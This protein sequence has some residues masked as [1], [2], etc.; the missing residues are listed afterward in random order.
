MRYEKLEHLMDLALDMQLNRRGVSIKDIENKFSVSRRTA[1]RMKDLVLNVFLDIEEITD[2]TRIKR[3]KIHET[4]FSKLLPYNND[5]IADLTLAA[6]TLK[7][8][9]LGKQSE[10]IFNLIKKLKSTLRKQFLLKLETDL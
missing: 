2:D 7:N 10:S 3:W 6:K 9:N 8:N 4:Q 1:I 5:D